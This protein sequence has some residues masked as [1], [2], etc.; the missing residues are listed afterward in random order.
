MTEDLDPREEAAR[1]REKTKDFLNVLGRDAKDPVTLAAAVNVTETEH[2]CRALYCIAR[3]L[4]IGNEQAR[5]AQ[6]ARGWVE[7]DATSG[8]EPPAGLDA[9]DMVDVEYR[10]GFVEARERVRGLLWQQ[11]GG[12]DDIVAY[13]VS[14]F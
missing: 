11:D 3:Q 7:W 14:R 6:N 9:S 5:S 8:T 4:Q 1:L 12:P 13:R 10:N 2:I